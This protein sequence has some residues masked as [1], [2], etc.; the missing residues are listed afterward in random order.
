MRDSS[1]IRRAYDAVS[2]FAILNLIVVTGAAAYLFGTGVVTQERLRSVVDFV[3][4]AEAAAEEDAEQAAADIETSTEDQ[5]S[6]ERYANAVGSLSAEILRREADRVKAELDQQ[7]AL[8]HSIMLRITEE[9]D[10]FKRE[11]ETEAARKA[12][13]QEELASSGFEK[14]RTL[15]NELSPKVAVKHLLSLTDPTDAAKILASLDIRKAK[16][17]IESAKTPE[18]QQ[19]M[20]AV[21]QKMSEVAPAQNK[22]L[23]SPGS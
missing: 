18:E 4:T 20:Q 6:N 14:Q 21:L 12:A 8:S 1:M 13:E 5:A 19:K 7:L 2:L 11:R 10:A 3:R 23:E 15:F 22:A 9:R 17:I 16:R